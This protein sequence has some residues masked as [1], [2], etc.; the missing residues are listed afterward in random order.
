MTRTTKE[1]RKAILRAFERIQ[2]KEG[3]SYRDLRAKAYPTFGMDGAIGLPW[4]GMHLCIEKD[5]YTHS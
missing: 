1:Q 2:D 5:G 4:C 3:M